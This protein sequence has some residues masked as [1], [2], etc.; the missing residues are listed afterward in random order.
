MSDTHPD[1]DSATSSDDEEE[2]SVPTVVPFSAE[3]FWLDQSGG[4]GSLSREDAWV[5]SNSRRSPNDGRSHTRTTFY[6]EDTQ[7]RGPGQAHRKPANRRSWGE[8]AKWNDGMYSDKSRGSQ[9][10]WADNHRWVD[11][12]TDRVGANSHQCEKTRHT[13]ETI[14][15]DPY[16]KAGIQMELLIL[17]ICSVFIDKEIEVGP[18]ET[19]ADAMDRRTIERE[20]THEVLDAIGATRQDFIEARRFLLET[21]GEHFE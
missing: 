6:P 8:L 7:T 17:V 11:I 2:G 19:P 20:G 14:T 9:N 16:P 15:A 13:L 5:Q 18:D 1:T 10:H 3:D 4:S 21:D 12:V